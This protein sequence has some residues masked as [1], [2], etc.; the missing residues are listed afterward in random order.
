MS[1]NK[2]P[3]IRYKCILMCNTLQKQE[4]SLFGGGS[5]VQWGSHAFA[6]IH[7]WN[8]LLSGLR[9]V[10]GDAA[11]E[12]TNGAVKRFPDWRRNKATRRGS[13]LKKDLPDHVHHEDDIE[14]DEEVVCVP[15]DLVVG[16]PEDRKEMF[17]KPDH[18]K[19]TYEAY[20]KK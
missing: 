20:L 2:H 1:R 5:D 3:D 6:D 8:H 17:L 7:M 9:E 13:Q 19:E 16:H 4:D 14:D 15:E 10:E 18:Q 12:C 11:T